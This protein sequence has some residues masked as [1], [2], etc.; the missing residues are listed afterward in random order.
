MPL[1]KSLPDTN[2]AVRE[3]SAF[4]LGRQGALSTS[5]VPALTTLLKD[6][7]ESV[8]RAAKEALERINSATAN[9][10]DLTPPP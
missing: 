6:D 2:A 7:E 3:W 9:G 8:R 4:A 5:A 10:G 1:T